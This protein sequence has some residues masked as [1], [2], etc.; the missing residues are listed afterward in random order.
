[1]EGNQMYQIVSPKKSIVE[2]LKSAREA[3]GA[4]ARVAVETNG[5]DIEG[6]E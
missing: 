6:L 3:G 1:M 2:K 4:P 5:E